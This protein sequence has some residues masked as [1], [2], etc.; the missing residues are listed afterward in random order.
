MFSVW[1]WWSRYVSATPVEGGGGETFNVLLGAD[2]VVLDP[3]SVV[4]TIPE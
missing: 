4:L 1:N 2:R 3:D